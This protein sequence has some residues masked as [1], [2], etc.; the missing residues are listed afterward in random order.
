MSED[1]KIPKGV[2]DLE[3]WE[4][5]LEAQ[6]ELENHPDKIIIVKDLDG[7]D[8]Y[9][10]LAA[11][12]YI[13]KKQLKNVKEELHKD[14]LDKVPEFRKMIVRMSVLKRKAF[15]NLSSD[16]KTEETDGLGPVAIKKAEIIDLFGRFYNL[17]EVHKIITLDWGY[18]I[19]IESIRQFKNKS[20]N[21]IIQ[22]QKEYEENFSDVRLGKRRSRLDELSWIYSKTKDKYIRAEA[23]EDAKLMQSLLES[24]K[25]ECDGDLVI[26]AKMEI[27]VQHTIN[28][29]I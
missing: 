9:I 20:A 2:V 24:I 3:M 5:Y 29:Q 11:T 16:N 27:D 25:K 6:A 1:K 10:N 13:I 18:D 12:V 4:L 26:N 19:S 8:I 22:L 17:A 28:L 14:I 15:G 21:Q 7:K 23:R